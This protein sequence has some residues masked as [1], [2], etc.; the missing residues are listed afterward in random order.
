MPLWM[1]EGDAV[2]TETEMST[3]GRGLQPSFTMH[4]RAIGDV[5]DEYK[6][7]DKWICGS[8]KDY[9][10][11]HYSLGYLVCRHSYNRFGTIIGN[12]V[13]ELMKRRPYM[14]ISNT[15]I[16]R[17]LY[18]VSQPEPVRGYVRHPA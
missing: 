3:Y 6:N 18:G 5:Y 9:I 10:P 17:R 12:D 7:F 13:A 4:Y 14:V 2:Q 8:Y 16:F 15:W 1:M 11:N